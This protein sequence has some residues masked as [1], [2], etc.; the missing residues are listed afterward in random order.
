MSIGNDGDI[1]ERHG[2][3]VSV[4]PSSQ[5]HRNDQQSSYHS[6]GSRKAGARQDHD[7]ALVYLF[8]AI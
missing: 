7:L 1:H 5:G 3:F 6:S 2:L 8:H 4:Q